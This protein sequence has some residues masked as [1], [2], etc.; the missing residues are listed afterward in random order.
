MTN[1]RA[2]AWFAVFAVAVFACGLASGILV[3]RLLVPP[4]PI[5]PFGRAMAMRGPNPDRL[6]DRLAREL[7]LTGEQRTRVRDI[8]E[9]R[10]GH[11]QQMHRELRADA[12]R[13]FE[14]EQAALR[15]E[16]RKV[17][18]PEQQA[19]FDAMVKQGPERLWPGPGRFLGAPPSGDP[20]AR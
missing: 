15:E 13:R 8:F 2:A 16:L 17:L 4:G 6:A 12:R 5:F 14:A 18:T 10:R 7:S 19:K 9:S 1:R 3:D 11:V 20:P